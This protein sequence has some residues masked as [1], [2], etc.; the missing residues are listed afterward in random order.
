MTAKL[1]FKTILLHTCPACL[2]RAEMNMY[3]SLEQFRDDVIECASC[4]VTWKRQEAFN[5]EMNFMYGHE[6]FAQ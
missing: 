4:G 6:G 1:K 2:F 3:R 5:W